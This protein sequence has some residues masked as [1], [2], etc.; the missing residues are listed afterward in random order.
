MIKEIGT[1][2]CFKI[3]SLNSPQITGENASVTIVD[4]ATE[5]RTGCRPNASETHLS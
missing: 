3:L 5:F 4:T 1:V 2:A